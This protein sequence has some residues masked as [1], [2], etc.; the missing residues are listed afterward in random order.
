MGQFDRGEF[1]CRLTSREAMD[2]CLVPPVLL[3]RYGRFSVDGNLGKA[4]A[5][6]VSE[7]DKVDGGP[8]D[9]S[10]RHRNTRS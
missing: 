8:A 1:G 4:E 2:R 3:V 9:E 6:N 5:V 7:T 10:A